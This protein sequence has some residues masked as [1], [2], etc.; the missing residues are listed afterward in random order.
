MML[1]KRIT[2]EQE[3]KHSK[4]WIKTIYIFGIPVAKW[5]YYWKEEDNN[6]LGFKK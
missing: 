2:N 4:E 3:D 1:F 6:K 5:E